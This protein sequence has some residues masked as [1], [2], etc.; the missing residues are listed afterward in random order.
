MKPT[1]K[2]LPLRKLIWRMR[3]MQAFPILQAIVEAYK[4]QRTNLWSIKRGMLWSKPQNIMQNT[5]QAN[6]SFTMKTMTCIAKY[7]TLSKGRLAYTSLGKNSRSI[8]NPSMRK[9]RSFS[10]ISSS[11]EKRTLIWRQMLWSYL[12]NINI[13]KMISRELTPFWRM[14]S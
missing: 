7:G 10:K 3:D 4:N 5:G 9:I 13:I 14:R 1:S 6:F 12:S 8:G 2:K 11:G